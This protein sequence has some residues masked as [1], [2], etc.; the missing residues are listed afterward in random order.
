MVTKT[1]LP[2]GLDFRRHR[3]IKGYG[4]AASGASDT[5]IPTVFQT[6]GAA[7][8]QARIEVVAWR[9]FRLRHLTR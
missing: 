4:S 2:A 3:L 9:R 5:P 6:S 1:T 8:R 7:L